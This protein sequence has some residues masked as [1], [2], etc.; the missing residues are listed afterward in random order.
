MKNDLIWGF[1]IQL[2]H[3]MWSE[4]PLVGEPKPEDRDN[5]AQPFNRTD[6]KVWNELTEYYAKR[7]ANLV[8]IDLGE[9]LAY[10]SH[11]ELAVK[12]SW[13]AARM[14]EEIARLRGLGLA[15]QE[16]SRLSKLISP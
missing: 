10:P 1:M 9:G 3:N 14:K 7:G 15:T 8:L 2:G 12:G 16:M 4:E 11:P 5:Y 13:P 6:V